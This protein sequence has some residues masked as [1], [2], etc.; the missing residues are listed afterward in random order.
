MKKSEWNDKQLEELLQ[1]MPKVSD[2]QSPDELY[3]KIQAR[4]Q[5]EQVQ[6]NT[7]KKTW[8]LPSIATVAALILIFLITSNM[9]DIQILGSGS[10]EKAQME[11]SAVQDPGKSESEGATDARIAENS[12]AA[13][14]KDSGETGPNSIMMTVPEKTV[15]LVDEVPDGQTLITVGVKEYNVNFSFP[16]SFLYSDNKMT[17]FEMLQ[18]AISKIQEEDLGVNHEMGKY[19]L[20]KITDTEVKIIL[21]NDQ[22]VS[23]SGQEISSSI[24]ETFRWMN[25]QRAQVVYEDGRQVEDSMSGGT[26]GPIQIEKNLRKGYVVHHT[27]KGNVFLVP[28]LSPSNSFTEALELMTQ[29][30]ASILPSIEQGLIENVTTEGNTV[31]IKFAREIENST[32][33]DLMLKAILLTAKEFEF[34]NVKFENTV[35]QIGEYPIK[36]KSGNA[37]PIDVPIAPNYMEIPK[38]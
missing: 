32:K 26:V 4:L 23:A 25:Y 7:K 30:T 12:D 11:E 19:T 38:K 5:E 6:H 17:K 14:F 24:I 13:S 31:T 8:V 20:E 15:P 1:S 18:D 29:S 36:D 28:T 21:S 35:E 33:H 34:E 22:I 27:P 37:L 10:N 9:T 2:R 16:I 3:R